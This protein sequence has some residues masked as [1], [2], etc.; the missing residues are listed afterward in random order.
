[1]FLHIPWCSGAM[2]QFWG[3]TKLSIRVTCKSSWVWSKFFKLASHCLSGWKTH[4]RAGK[5]SKE[6]SHEKRGPRIRK[7]MGSKGLWR[8]VDGLAV[9]P[10]L[11]VI[12]DGIPVRSDGKMLATE[13][14]LEVKETRIIDFKKREYLA[15]HII[16]LTTSIH[17]GAKIKHLCKYSRSYVE[18]CKSRCNYKEHSLYFGCRRSVINNANNQ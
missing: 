9:A 4:Q 13:E 3:W 14:Q 2:H 16:L 12:V 10:K 15:Q 7:A 5:H 17:L 18:G 8:H 11:Y 1:M 6:N